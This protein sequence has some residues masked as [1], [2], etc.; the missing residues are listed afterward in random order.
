MSFNNGLLSEGYVYRCSVRCFSVHPFLMYL[1]KGMVWAMEEPVA[2]IA[3][4]TM[5]QSSN[6]LF[7]LFTE[8]LYP[9]GHG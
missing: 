8:E 2:M 9:Y 6:A 7:L 5:L 4:A 3:S 1:P